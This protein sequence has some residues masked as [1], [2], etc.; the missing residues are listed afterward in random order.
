MYVSPGFSKYEFIPTYTLQEVIFDILPARIVDECGTEYE[1]VYRK[2][3]DNPELSYYSIESEIYLC[4]SEKHY[5][6]DAMYELLIE[7]TD[8]DLIPSL[9]NKNDKK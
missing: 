1:F 9:N 2:G 8:R 7:L 4:W 5:P 3:G 6:M